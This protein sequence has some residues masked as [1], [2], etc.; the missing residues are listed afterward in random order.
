MKLASVINNH[1]L[2]QH[3]Q[4]AVLLLLMQA[5]QLEC[6]R[7]MT[8]TCCQRRLTTNARTGSEPLSTFSTLSLVEVY[9][10]RLHRVPN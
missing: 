1:C 7:R 4:Q 8:V 2:V 10:V 6:H 3:S 9:F 5:T